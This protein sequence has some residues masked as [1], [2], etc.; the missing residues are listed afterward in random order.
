MKESRNFRLAP[1]VLETL[2]HLAEQWHVS[3]AQA[4]EILI[5]EAKREKRELRTIKA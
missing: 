5:R 4:L 2:Q 3:Q 1:E